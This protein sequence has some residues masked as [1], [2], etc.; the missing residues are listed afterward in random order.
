MEEQNE[1]KYRFFNKRIQ[2]YTAKA[3]ELSI[4]G[5]EKVPVYYVIRFFLNGIKKGYIATRASAIAFNFAIA[6]FPTVI[7]LFTL[8]PYIP[9]NNFQAELMELLQDIL[10]ENAFA[11]FK[12]TLISI[13]TKKNTGFLSIGLIVSLFFSTNGIHALIQA[14]NNTYHS[15]ETRSWLAIRT[16]SIFL[17]LVTA[18]LIAIAI[19]LLIFSQTTLNKLVEMGILEVNITYYLLMFGKWIIIAGL[20][21]FVI[22]FLYY[23]A[24]AKKTEWKFI[25][26]GSTLATILAL[27]ASIGFSYFVNS[28]G[29]YNKLYG[30]IGTIMVILLWLYFNSFALLIGF[31]LNAS[32]NNAQYLTPKITDHEKGS[33]TN[34]EGV[35]S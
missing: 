26:A 11:Y 8:I 30:S 27:L 13:I 20:F 10:P 17:V 5:F 22:S 14:F 24:P 34:T 18:F 16:V 6:V 1:I 2:H 31:E 35:Q 3:K 21:F 12:S 19:S 28:F 32:I 4:P 25:S 9:V 33:V 23:Y 15:I 29:Q 7:F